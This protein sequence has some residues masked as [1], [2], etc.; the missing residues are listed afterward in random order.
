MIGILGLNY[1]VSTL[2]KFQLY[3]TYRGN[4]YLEIVDVTILLFYMQGKSPWCSGGG[5]VWRILKGV[6]IEDLR[7]GIQLRR[8]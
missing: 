2:D 6:D 7:V 8:K 3:Y 1:G 5:G 4:H